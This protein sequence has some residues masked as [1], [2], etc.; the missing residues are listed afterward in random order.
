M[1]WPFYIQRTA[2]H[3]TPSHPLAPTF[4]LPPVVWQYSWE[5]TNKLT[6]HMEP[7]R[8]QSM[9]TTKIGLFN[10]WVSSRLLT[11]VRVRNHLQ[12]QK[13]LRD[14]CHQS[15]P[16]TGDNSE[17]LDTWSA[18]YIL[19][20]R[21]LEANLS[22]AAQWLWAISSS[23]GLCLFVSSLLVW[24]QLAV[25]LTAYVCLGWEGPNASSQL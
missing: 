21:K 25:I 13:W 6:P 23:A 1:Q 18:P 11:E 7:L 12:E 20:L 15:P 17:N 9:N 2:F 8:V 3:K 5:N 22:Q 14:S 19:Q 16:S 10:Q 4:F 24:E